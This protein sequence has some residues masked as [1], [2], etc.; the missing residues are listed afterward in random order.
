MYTIYGLVL[1][2]SEVLL[3]LGRNSVYEVV[4]IFPLFVRN[5]INWFPFVF[6]ERRICAQYGLLYIWIEPSNKWYLL[7]YTYY[8]FHTQEG[9][10]T[11]TD[12]VF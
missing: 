11:V 5:I 3:F 8:Y 9:E 4:A 1:T 7:I 12:F 2:F 6:Q 10:L